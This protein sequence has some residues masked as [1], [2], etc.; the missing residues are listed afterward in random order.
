[1]EGMLMNLAAS[2]LVSAMAG[3]PPAD[4]HPEARFAKM[5]AEQVRAYE[6]DVMRRVADLSLIP[7]KLKMLISRPLR[8]RK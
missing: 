2:S 4:D 6:Q 8:G 3:T 5:T 7:P 1:M